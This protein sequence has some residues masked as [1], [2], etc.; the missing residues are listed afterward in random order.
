LVR[1][2]IAQAE[3]PEGKAG[4]PRTVVRTAQSARK[5]SPPGRATDPIARRL[6]NHPS[7]GRNAA[8]I[9]PPLLGEIERRWQARFDG[10]EIGCVRRALE[11]VLEQIDLELPHGLPGLWDAVGAY[12][13]R[14]APGAGPQP[15]PALLSQV[16][17]AY[18]IEFDRESP[19]P[20]NL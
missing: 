10:D 18:A 11:G 14:G 17:L 5:R 3:R 1:A 4:Q 12:P 16:L 20:L 9:W 2:A 19:T 6:A 13:A 7:G 8:E 15:L